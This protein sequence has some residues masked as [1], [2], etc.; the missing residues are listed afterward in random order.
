MGGGDPVIL[1]LVITVAVAWA[2]IGAL[3]VLV[4]LGVGKLARRRGS[5][6]EHF[7]QAAAI[8]RED[9]P[10]PD[11]AAWEREWRKWAPRI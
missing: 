4:V 1:V 10:E 3:A 8:I 2:A 9:E 7:D 11:F 6:D 5:F